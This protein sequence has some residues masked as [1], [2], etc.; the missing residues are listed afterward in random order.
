MAWP[1][2]R[3]VWRREEEKSELGFAFVW[4][5]GAGGPPMACKEERGGMRGH[6]EQQTQSSGGKGQRNNKDKIGPTYLQSN[7]RDRADKPA[8]V[9]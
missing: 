6:T 9:Q 5:N 3:A 8:T 4:V 1:M 2:M 7:A